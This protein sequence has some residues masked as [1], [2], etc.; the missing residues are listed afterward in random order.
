M[1]RC[2]AALG[3]PEL[4][5]VLSCNRDAALIEGFNPSVTLVRTQTIMEGAPCCD[6]RY[7]KA[8]KSAAGR[9]HEGHEGDSGSQQITNGSR[10]LPIARDVTRS[11]DHQIIRF[12]SFD[13]SF[14]CLPGAQEEHTMTL[15][16]IFTLVAVLVGLAASGL[17]AAA[18]QRGSGPHR[19]R[20]HGGPGMA[21]IT[22]RVHRPLSGA[23]VPRAALLC[24]TCHTASG[25]GTAW[26][27][28]CGS[29]S[30]CRSRGTAM[31]RSGTGFRHTPAAA[32]PT[33]CP[34][35]FPIRCLHR[36]PATHRS[37]PSTRRQARPARSA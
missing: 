22:G 25:P 33:R 19:G 2:T 8:T 35:P 3:I 23:G 29:A 6:F 7:T 18:D 37:R 15:A 27:A 24:S 32:R 11:P 5:A 13:V 16:R 31:H 14:P 36:Q 17:T 1:P 26:A 4:G 10:D 30:R 28:A 12:V 34:I 9:R 20:G 21:V